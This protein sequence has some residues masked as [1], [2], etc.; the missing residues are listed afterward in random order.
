MLPLTG[1]SLIA[2]LAALFG[3]FVAVEI[4]IVA[5]IPM[6]TEVLPEARAVMMSSNAGAQSCGRFIGAFL[7]GVLY[8]VSGFGVVSGGAV[9]LGLAAFITMLL[10]VKEA[11]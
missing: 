5:S 4:A 9:L 1:F 7:G 11:P 3:V 10:Y 2:F 6:F 8:Q